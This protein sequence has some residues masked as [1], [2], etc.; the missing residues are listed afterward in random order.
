MT[1]DYTNLLGSARLKRFFYSPYFLRFTDD[2]AEFRNEVLHFNVILRGTKFFA[3]N[4]LYPF[5]Y[6]IVY[7]WLHRQIITDRDL[8][9]NENG[10]AFRR[11]EKVGRGKF[12]DFCEAMI[13]NGI[14][15]SETTL[16]TYAQ[17]TAPKR[18][19]AVKYEKVKE[20]FELYIASYPDM[21]STDAK[22]QLKLF[23]DQVEA[24]TE[25]KANDG[26]EIQPGALSE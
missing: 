11:L 23:M 16:E 4:D 2:E 17:I 9:V 24:L 5:K 25:E 19:S 21:F 14:T 20:L 22:I 15:L 8:F 3:N 7:D 6:E 26:E 10:K 13:K 1:L 18:K 12:K